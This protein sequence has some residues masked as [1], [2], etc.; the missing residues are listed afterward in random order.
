MGVTVYN[1]EGCF[2]HTGFGVFH[3]RAYKEGFKMGISKR[4]LEIK[5][6][7]ISM[8]VDL[9]KSEFKLALEMS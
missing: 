5:D 3:L 2:N 9:E 4:W 6:V 7:D 8:Y 1:H